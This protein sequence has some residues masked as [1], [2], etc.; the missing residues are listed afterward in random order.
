MNLESPSI[1]AFATMTLM[2]SKLRAVGL[3]LAY[4]AHQQPATLDMPRQT[5]ATCKS[6]MERRICSNQQLKA[7]GSKTRQITSGSAVNRRVVGFESCLRNHRKSCIFSVCPTGHASCRATPKLR[8]KLGITHPYPNLPIGRRRGPPRI[9]PAG[10]TPARHSRPIPFHSS[11]SSDRKIPPRV[12]RRPSV[13]F[14]RLPA[15][16]WAAR[17][18]GLEVRVAECR[19]LINYRLTS[20]VVF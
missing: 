17:D 19:H 7:R 18:I 15:E 20:R 8:L 3:F 6:L 13:L 10:T 1:F 16:R 5:R 12:H 2:G 9:P 14:C 4:L 11:S